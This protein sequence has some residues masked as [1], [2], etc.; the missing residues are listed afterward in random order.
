MY[1]LLNL[2][3]SR[4][5]ENNFLGLSFC[6]DTE[7]AILPDGLLN[8]IKHKYPQ[9]GVNLGTIS[10]SFLAENLNVTKNQIHM[11]SCLYFF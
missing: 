8:V 10:L 2:W 9:V 7:V 1:I 5:N 6:R 3:L 11:L 4:S